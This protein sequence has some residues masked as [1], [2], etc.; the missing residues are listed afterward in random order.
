[1]KSKVV[2]V[3]NM[4]KHIAFIMDGNGR[5]AKKRGLPRSAGPAA[6]VKSLV[7]LLDGAYELGVKYVTVYAFSTEN[8]NR[9]KEEVDA[10]MG[11]M[12][13]YF[14]KEFNKLLKKKIKINVWGDVSAFDESL[15]QIINKV[16]EVEFDEPT[17][18]VN[19]ALNYGGRKEIVSAV[20]SAI[21]KGEPVTEET[22]S[23][24]FYSKNTPDPDIVVRTSGEMRI[25]NFLLYQCAYSEFYFTQTLWPDFSIK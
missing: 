13:R 10:L 7:K 21:E 25:S 16:Q 23:Q 3:N 2:D 6:G 4:P 17:G 19:I 24:L 15:S 12:R 5:W 9:P 22:F 20:N 8:W 14:D 11:L 18:V 1:M